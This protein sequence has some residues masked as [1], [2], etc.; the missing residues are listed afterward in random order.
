[1]G[2]W[3]AAQAVE[4][5]ILKVGVHPV[6]PFIVID[7]NGTEVDGLFADML[8][9]IAARKGW[10]IQYIP[11]SKRNNLARLEAGQIDLLMPMAA[12]PPRDGRIDLTRK[13]LITSWGR[14]YVANGARAQAWSDLSGKTVAVVSDDPYY[15]GLRHLLN[16]AM[17][18]CEFVEMR[19]YR[20]VFEALDRRRVDAGIVD[21]FFGEQNSDAYG[22]TASFLASPPVEFRFASPRNRNGIFTE[23]VDYWLALFQNDGRSPYYT[24]LSR[25]TDY[26]HTPP[27]ARLLV[28]LGLTLLLVT[29]IG[30]FL[31]YRQH[32]THAREGA[33]IDQSVQELRQ[34]IA[35]HEE[36]ERTLESWENWYQMLFS[37][38][39]DAVL[40]YGITPE[41]TPGHFVEANDQACAWLKYTREEI[42]SL[43]PRDIESMP[44]P[45]SAAARL[46]ETPPA[47][48]GRTPTRVSL[49]TGAELIKAIQEKELVSY[50]RVFRPK[51]GPDIPVEITATMLTHEGKP[52]I[53]C[54]AHDITTR[55]EAQRALQATERM[56][57]DFFAR[58]PIGIALCDAHQK[59]SDVN[60]SCLGMFGFSDRAQFTRL[61]LFEQAEVSDEDRKT[62]LKGG[63]V[64]FETVIDFDEAR[65]KQRFESS[66]SGKC[67]FDIIVTNLGLDQG[68]NPKGYLV[69]VQDITERRKAEEA[70]RQSERHLRQAQKMES[71]G[72]LAGGIA[73]DFN[74]LLTPIIGYTEMALLS[75]AAT[76]PIRA[77]LEE[78]LKASSRARDLVKQILTFSRQS[79]EELKPIRLS[80]I[81]SEVLGL[82]KVRLPPAIELRDSSQNARDIVRADPTQMH[83]VL[84]NL[85]T[86]AYHAMRDT[87]GVLE[88]RMREIKVDSRSRGALARLKHG[89]YVDLSV[90]DTGH[91]MDRQTMDR[92]FEPFFTTKR[93]G[94]GTGMG[95]AVVHGIVI[96]MQGIITVESEL[97]KG[98]TFHLCLPL[99]EQT[100]EPK[101]PES[102]PLPRG[103]ESIL[104][105]D[106]E[107]DIITM[108]NQMLSQLGYQTTL[109][110]RSSGALDVFREDP[111]RFDM[112]ITDQIMP[113]MTGLELTREVRRIR[114]DL[115]VIMCTGYSKTVSEED[116]ADAGVREML[117]KPVALRQLAESIRRAL[118]HKIRTPDAPADVTHLHTS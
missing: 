28:A 72:T 24:A 79:R 116:I 64:K 49:Q 110:D 97:G 53:M 1:M 91:G 18:R 99:L 68:F 115:P 19:D 92:I 88:I 85:C 8:E 17:V 80:P 103:S 55:R 82:L 70:L 33:V 113:G 5:T 25:W 48:D 71:I 105:V 86:N 32:R 22:V 106:D 87:G 31:F 96:N 3:T 57:H 37:R 6:E 10:Q 11:D 58:S 4:P 74:N 42:L 44:A 101:S 46:P 7:H 66:R 23:P 13:T 29:A 65:Q 40:M 41:R 52:V 30:G 50:E 98:S 2:L 34:T 12:T 84:M 14:V 100:T 26:G 35:A 89:T 77:Q 94:E 16:E 45:G 117:M 78:V 51:H 38:T 112:L 107:L 20:A 67:H 39:R 21:H 95:L 9:T 27:S 56:F 90:H 63:T 75:V 104:F 108:I 43:T 83:S 69:Q 15:Q 114:P 47:G 59:L 81:I 76:D 54:T 60:P 111:G 93:S 61:N 109:C 102:A 62:L 118:D 36:R 73:H